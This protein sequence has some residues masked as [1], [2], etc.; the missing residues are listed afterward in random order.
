MHMLVF[1]G[2]TGEGS[3]TC[4]LLALYEY[5][6]IENSLAAVRVRVHWLGLVE[7]RVSTLGLLGVVSLVRRGMLN[8]ESISFR[9]VMHLV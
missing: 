2:L 4:L 6:A 5:S 8:G 1:A 3:P 9:L 7:S